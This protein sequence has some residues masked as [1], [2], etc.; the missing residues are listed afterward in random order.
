MSRAKQFELAEARL[1][2]AKTISCNGTTYR[3]GKELNMPKCKI[4]F[5]TAV[6]NLVY[7]ESRGWAVEIN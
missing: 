6:A 4:D 3:I 7:W 5:E 1:R 2:N